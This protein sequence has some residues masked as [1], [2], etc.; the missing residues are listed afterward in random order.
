MRKAFLY[1][2]LDSLKAAREIWAGQKKYKEMDL[3]FDLFGMAWGWMNL[4][5]PVISSTFASFGNMCRDLGPNTIGHLFIDEAGQAVPQ[6]GVGAIMRSR[7]VMAVGDPAQIKPVVTIEPAILTMLGKHYAVGTKYISDYASVQTLTDAA[8]VYGFYRDKEKTE[9]SWIGIPLWVHRRCQYPMFTISN[10]LSYGGLMV[11]G[12]KKYGKCGWYDVKGRAVGKYVK[13]QGE[14]LVKKILEMARENPDILDGTKKDVVYVI[15]PFANVASKLVKDLDQIGFV[16]RS[17]KKPTNIGTVHT[18]QGKEAPIVFMVLGADKSSFGAAKWAV[19]EPNMMNV[20]ATRAKEEFYV[21]GDR[22]LYQGL[23]CEVINVTSR[24]MKDYA[25]EYPDK[26]S[27]LQEEEA[28]E[29]NDKKATM[30]E[31]QMG[32]PRARLKVTE[33]EEAEVEEDVE[34][35]E[36]RVSPVQLMERHSSAQ[37]EERKAPMPEQKVA[38]PEK[39]V[40]LPDQKKAGAP[41]SMPKNTTQ[42]SSPVP[43]GKTAADST[44]RIK[45]KVKVVRQGSRSFYAYVSGSDKVEYTI[46]E[47]IFE[48]TADAVHVILKDK[49]I[50][51]IP[52]TSG[53]SPQA[54]D[55]LPG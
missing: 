42:T 27:G 40:S 24:V 47:R 28:R 3:D 21:I 6:A 7:H 33:E 22:S 2:N 45:G 19:S 13:E 17:D 34:L 25:K 44:G 49:I 11:Q 37:A 12:A 20:A 41:V 30:A 46:N 53:K 31:G 14:F 1:K 26:V 10:E 15:T 36:R 18:F 23:G 9:Q 55:I 38:V 52:D 16:R 29:E 43:T 48:A 50:S 39:K 8:S 32:R 54:K 5:I 4:A 51:F 35:K